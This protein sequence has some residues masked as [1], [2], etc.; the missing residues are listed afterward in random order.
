[1]KHVMPI[2]SKDQLEEIKKILRDQSE[3]N[4]IMF[5]IGINA[6]LRISDILPLRVRDVRGECIL[7]TEQKTG[8]L[9]EIPINTSLQRALRRY[10]HG[11]K[12]NEILIKS[13]EGINEPISRSMA[14][15][16]IREAGEQA[17]VMR[18]GTHTMRKTFGYHYYQRTKDIEALRKMLNHSDADITRRYIGIEQDFIKEQYLK[19]TNL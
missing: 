18:L 3:R 12:D 13:R 1:M 16:I 19:H 6:A 15:K 14:Y 8:N 10:L 9:R 7:L 11:K 17:G 2:R 4:Y 5:M